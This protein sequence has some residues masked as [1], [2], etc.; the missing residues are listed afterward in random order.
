MQ[1]VGL[2]ARGEVTLDEVPFP[3]AGRVLVIGSE[4][5]GLRRLTREHCEILAR[6]DM[7]GG[8]ESLNASVAAGIALYATARARVAAHGPPTPSEAPARV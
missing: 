6:I 1:V 2:D 5:E 4:G 8:F 3:A 7:P